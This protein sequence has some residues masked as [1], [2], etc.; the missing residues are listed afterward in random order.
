MVGCQHRFSG[1]ELGQTPGDSEGRGKPGV[2]QSMGLKRVEHDLMTEKHHQALS[3][4]S[5]VNSQDSHPDHR[6]GTSQRKSRGQNLSLCSSPSLDS[7]LSL[8]S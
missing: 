8:V 6:F 7:L 3:I 2:L 4:H 1:H 5:Y